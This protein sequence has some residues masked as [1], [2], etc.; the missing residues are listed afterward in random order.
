[1]HVSMGQPNTHIHKPKLSKA[2]DALRSPDAMQ[3]MHLNE[4]T[5]RNTNIH[6]NNN[7]SM[8][9]NKFNNKLSMYEHKYI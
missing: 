2:Q 8:I 5:C 6:A 4:V 9:Q 3:S 1:M 7:E